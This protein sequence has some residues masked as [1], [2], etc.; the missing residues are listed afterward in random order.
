MFRSLRVKVKG[1]SSILMHNEQL[2]DP[3]NPIA[4]AMKEIT[5]KRKKTDSDYQALADLEWQGGL[6][7][8]EKNRPVIPGEII[9][10]T[11]IAG[12]R[13][14]RLGEQSKSAIVCD[15]NWPLAYEGPKTADKLKPLPQFRSTMGVVVNRSRVMRTRPIFSNWSLEFDLQYDD[16]SLN[17]EQV[18]QVLGIAGKQCGFCDNR[19]KFGRFE[20]LKITPLDA[21]AAG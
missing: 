7:L 21:A 16:E 19:P 4:R 10:A 13:K 8:D 5:S 2:A 9:E 3:T 20:V 6:Y 17:L 12:A 18:K 1:V 11:F 14:L 15:D